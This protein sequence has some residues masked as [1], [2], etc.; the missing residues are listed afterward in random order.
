MT[1]VL[2]ITYYWPPSGGPGVQRWLKFVKY[3]REFGIDPIVYT[4]DKKNF[5]IEDDSLNEDIPVSVEVLKKPIWEPGKIFSGHNRKK[6]ESIGFLSEKPGFF[7]RLI[8][9][10]RANYFIPDAKKFWID[11]S[12]KFIKSYLEK[13]SVDAIISTGPPHS[14]HLI[15][16]RLKTMLGVKWIADFRDP[17]TEIDYFHQLPLTKQ[18]RRKHEK[19]ER[20]VLERADRVVVVSDY[21]KSQFTRINRS[22]ITITNGFDSEIVERTDPLD[23]HFSL[24]HIGMMNETRNPDTLWKI[25]EELKRENKDFKSRLKLKLIGKL[26]EEVRR[27][28]TQR[29]LQEELEEIDYLPHNS[30]MD[31]LRSAQ[32]LLLVVNDVPAAKGIV[33][34]K[35]F[36]YLAS[37]RP[38]LAIG[39]TDGDLAKILK[40]SGAGQIVDRKDEKGL[41]KVLLDLFNIY[42]TT[43]LKSTAAEKVIGQYH[44]K[45]LTKAYSKLIT[46]L[47]K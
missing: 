37:G 36:E 28:V 10:I 13:N 39:P 45:E 33:T 43:G 19:L 5:Q 25:L 21:M 1:K 7:T 4:V 26:A 22:T 29:E 14:L 47:C 20:K 12:V 31:H 30:I 17:W 2:I 8:Y 16:L 40:K 3:F 35:V 18:A 23:R 24:V 6:K 11:P 42:T 32:V 27:S 9:F 41:K 34:G 46:E 38:I 15:A 44:R